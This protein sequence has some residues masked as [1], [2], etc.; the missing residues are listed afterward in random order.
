[1]LVLFA[2]AITAMFSIDL[3]RV[4]NRG[5]FYILMLCSTLG[6]MLMA[7]SADIVM[8]YLSIETTSIPLYVLA[9][10]LIRDDKS[11]ESGFKYLLFGALTSAIML[12]GFSLLYGFTGTQIFMFFRR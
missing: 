2:A 8:L 9:G 4:G 3:P 5:E 6:M 11:T 12:Y 10:F 1:M 7:S